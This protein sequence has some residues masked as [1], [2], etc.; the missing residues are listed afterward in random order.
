M[1]EALIDCRCHTHRLRSRGSVMLGPI[2]ING[3]A[4]TTVKHMPGCA[5]AA[6]NQTS[7]SRMVQVSYSGLR[8][9]LSMAVSFSISLNTGAGGVSISPS[10]TVRPVVDR[11]VSPAFQIINLVA[12]C[13]WNSKWLETS[14]QTRVLNL[15]L[16]RLS[17]LYEE[18]KASP[19]E[20][21]IYGSTLVHSYTK[22]MV[23]LIGISRLL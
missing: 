20:V 22:S 21:D 5:Y 7:T 6:I 19:Y 2:I 3:E 11:G 23:C 17:R 9:L 13:S 16:Q 15:S 14:L 1:S 10:I 4:T 18:R 12:R 8:S